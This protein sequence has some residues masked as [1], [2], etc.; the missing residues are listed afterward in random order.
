MKLIKYKCKDISFVKKANN[1]KII[2]IID[3]FTA[4]FGDSF[5]VE[6]LFNTLKQKI[7]ER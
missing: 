3:V 4:K 6:L 2:S 1:K 5:N 7:F